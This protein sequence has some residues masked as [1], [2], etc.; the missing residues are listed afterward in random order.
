MNLLVGFVRRAP[1]PLRYR[2]L[3]KL[4]RTFWRGGTAEARGRRLLR[5]WLSK[6]QRGQFDA[7]NFFDV[8]GA[9]TGKRYRIH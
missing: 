7:M 5:H 8:T 6:E 9:Q 3:R 4:Y 1:D 2:A